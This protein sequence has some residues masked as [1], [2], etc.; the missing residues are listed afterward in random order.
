MGKKKFKKKMK[1]RN[2]ISLKYMLVF[3]LFMIVGIF[4][5]IFA[6]KPFSNIPIFDSIVGD[7]YAYVTPIM[8]FSELLPA[9][10]ILLGILGTLIIVYIIMRFF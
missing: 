8:L 3:S 6:F 2:P 7:N 9:I 4:A 10:L 1:F 5:I